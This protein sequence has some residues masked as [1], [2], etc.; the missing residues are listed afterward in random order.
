MLATGVHSYL[1]DIP[2]FSFIYLSLSTCTKNLSTKH[3][4]ILFFLS[5]G[6]P[7]TVLKGGT[8]V[9]FASSL[10]KLWSRRWLVGIWQCACKLGGGIFTIK[11]YRKRATFAEFT[12]NIYFSALCFYKLFTDC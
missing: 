8:W 10:T 4:F 1:S 5:V 6:N 9:G 2:L 11:K 3:K 12:L 7:Q